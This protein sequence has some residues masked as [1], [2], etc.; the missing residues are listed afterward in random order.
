MAGP[1]FRLGV[2]GDADTQ[3]SLRQRV[4]RAP[5][6]PLDKSTIVSVFPRR[7]DE[8]KHTIQPGRFIIEPG[9]YEN[10][11]ILV[12]GSSSWWKEMDEGQP[13]L[14]IPTGSIQVADSVVKDYAVGLLACDMGSAMPGLFYVPGEYDVDGIRENFPEELEKAKFKQKNWY[15]AL[16][17]FADVL[18][19][20]SDGNP[21]AISDEMKL[22]AHDLNLKDK[23]WLK[24]YQTMQMEHCP[25]CGAL[26]NP[27][28]PMCQ[29]CKTIVDPDKFAALGLQKASEEV[30]TIEKP[31]NLTQLLEKEQQDGNAG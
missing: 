15:R 5:V 13:H 4:I 3:R 7:I 30:I 21:R 27:N 11:A 23:P 20:Q 31:S 24:D 10:P 12:V 16:I 1:T 22:A 8:K 18:W 17:E 2:P 29:N 25:A 14:E 9:T 6:N 26:W 19:A 28:Y